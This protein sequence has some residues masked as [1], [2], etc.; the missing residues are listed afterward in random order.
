MYAAVIQHLTLQ[1]NTSVGFV[2]GTSEWSSCGVTIPGE[3][4]ECD[5]TRDVHCVLIN[6]SD[7]RQ[8]VPPFHCSV[9]LKPSKQEHCGLCV[10]SCVLSEWGDWS[11]CSATCSGAAVKHRVRGILSPSSDD[12]PCPPLVDRRTC[13]ELPICHQDSTPLY[14]WMARP[15]TGCYQVSHTITMSCY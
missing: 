7:E 3:C 9:E 15:W 11:Q 13:T 2:W 1:T 14:H 5:R 6:R 10:R 4:C 8:V 12:L